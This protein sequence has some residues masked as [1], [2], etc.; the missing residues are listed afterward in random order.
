M[1]LERV[2]PPEGATVCGVALPPGTVVGIMAPIVNNNRDVFG[3][4]ADTFR[5]ER[6]MD[7][8]I[9]HLKVM[10]RTFFSVSTSFN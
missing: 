3:A 8:N 4:D 9:E 2:T 7:G 5:P 10:E 6:W 1:P